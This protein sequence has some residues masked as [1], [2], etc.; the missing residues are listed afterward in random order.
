M[1]NPAI[2]AKAGDIG[3]RSQ[4]A[5][6]I[7]GDFYDLIPLRRDAVGVCI[8]DVAGH[9]ITA[10]LLMAHVVSAVGILA[11]SSASP[12]ETLERLLE[13]IGDE[14]R[15]TDMHVS[16]F[17]AVVDRRVGVLRYAN[18]GHPHAWLVPGGGGGPKR[19]GATAPPLGLGHERTVLGAEFQWR[20]REDLLCLFTDGIS[21]SIGADGE[22]YGEQRVL[23]VVR[24]HRAQACRD[25]VDA[26]FHDLVAYAGDV[27]QDDRTILVLRR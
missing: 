9:N 3:A 1:P 18:A 24:R 17:Y 2:L 6:T 23:A 16:V 8:G 25:I 20:P 14:L 21:E 4:P 26:V 10:A 27:A 13:V 19:L 5:E 11:Q 22:T 7:G 12:E 15:N